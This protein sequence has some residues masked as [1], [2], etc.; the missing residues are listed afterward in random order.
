MV[1]SGPFQAIRFPYPEPLQGRGFWGQQTSTLNW[2][3]EDYI[4][5]HY[6]AELCNTLT[7]LAFLYLGF[8]GIRSCLRQS[9]DKIFLIAYGGYVLVGLGSIAFHASLK[10]PMQLWDELSMIYTTCLMMF[11]SF[12]YSRSALFSTVFGLGLLGLSAFIS[13]YYHTT[14]DPEFHQTAYGILT[15]IVVLHGIR[16][17][18]TMWA[19]IAVGLSVFLCGFLVWN[20][21]NIYCSQIRRWRREIG[22]P[23]AV[24]LEGHGWWHLLTGLGMAILDLAPL[25]S[26][27]H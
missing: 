18:R 27:M 20:L 11:A 7:N 8:R 10:Y 5:T 2:C 21:D 22:L 19:M 3:E 16:T 4:L 6:C 15:A 1:S 24:F 26:S 13:I 12:S 17:I 9:H 23:W 14:K 25:H